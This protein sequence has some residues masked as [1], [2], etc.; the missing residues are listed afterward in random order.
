VV[1]SKRCGLEGVVAEAADVMVVVVILDFWVLLALAR[2]S[3]QWA[4]RGLHRPSFLKNQKPK[5]KKQKQENKN[6]NH[7][8]EL[9]Q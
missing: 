7:D 3:G 2:V 5:Q 1:E 8:A 9:P 6:L 4:C